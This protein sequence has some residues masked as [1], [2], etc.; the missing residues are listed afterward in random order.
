MKTLIGGKTFRVK[1]G[2]NSENRF[3]YW[4]PKAMRWLPIAKANVIFRDFSK[5]TDALLLEAAQLDDSNAALIVV[6]D[7]VGID[8]GDVAGAFFS[9]MDLEETWPCMAQETRLQLLRKYVER[10]TYDEG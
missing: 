9:G 2:E 1:R 7:A 10:E 4:S 8:T 6:Q 5:V 3:Y